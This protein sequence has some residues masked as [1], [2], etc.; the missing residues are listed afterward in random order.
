[1][2]A[3]L[4]ESVNESELVITIQAFPGD[5][6]RLCGFEDPQCWNHARWLVNDSDQV[7]DIAQP[8]CDE[9]VAAMVSQ[10]I[11]AES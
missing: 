6:P 8:A 1:M 5:E 11:A 7:V 9:H 4:E 2:G 3:E 10:A